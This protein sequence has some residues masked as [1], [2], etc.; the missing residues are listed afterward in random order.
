MPGNFPGVIGPV[1]IPLRNGRG[2]HHVGMVVGRG[3][4]RGVAARVLRIGDGARAG[5]IRALPRILPL[6][7]RGDL[8]GVRVH[9]LRAHTRV[10]Q[11]RPVH[12]H[13]VKLAGSPPDGAHE[14]GNNQG[15]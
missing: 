11:L 6:G 15:R 7:R 12:G 8:L 14:I 3:E 10:E 13:V 4:L 2:V 9:H 5:G 1:A